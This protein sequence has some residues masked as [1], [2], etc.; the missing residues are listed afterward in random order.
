MSDL[1]KLAEAAADEESAY[2]VGLLI[3][4][5][6][7]EFKAACDPQSILTLLDERDKYRAAL[8][9]MDCTTPICGMPEAPLCKRCEALS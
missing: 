4:E 6:R 8:E 9:D 1:G 3:G 2:A 5:A 7:A